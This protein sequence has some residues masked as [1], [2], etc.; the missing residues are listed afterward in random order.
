M[1]EVLCRAVIVRSHGVETALPWPH[2]VGALPSEEARPDFTPPGSAAHPFR[3]GEFDRALALRG[4]LDPLEVG[5]L[6]AAICLYQLDPEEPWPDAEDVLARLLEHE[7]IIV[8]GGVE[9]EVDGVVVLTPQCC[10]GLEQWREWTAF[11]AGGPPPWGGHSPDPHVAL[12]ADGRVEL[13]Y[14]GAALTRVERSALQAALLGLER[15]LAEFVGRLREW[16]EAVAPR[17]AGTLVDRLCRDLD[18][19]PRAAD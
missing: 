3:R 11:V 9:V 8:A 13:G 17:I 14:V 16:A 2:W 6:V 19:V 4:A 10:A 5:T 1:Q 18:L 15:D 7:A 12:A